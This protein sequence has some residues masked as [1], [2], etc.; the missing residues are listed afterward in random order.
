MLANTCQG[1]SSLYS[2]HFCHVSGV[3]TAP[4]N[5]RGLNKF[6]SAIS[7]KETKLLKYIKNLSS[8]KNV[9]TRHEPRTEKYLNIE[10]HL[11]NRM[12]SVFHS[13]HDYFMVIS[14]NYIIYLFHKVRNKLVIPLKIYNI[15]MIKRVDHLHF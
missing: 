6:L 10:R 4:S 14:T 11:N 9:C 7:T 2:R 15:M 3:E 8:D 1:S 13:I 12:K 5:F